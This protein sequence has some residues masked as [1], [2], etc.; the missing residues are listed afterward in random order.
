MIPASASPVIR[1]WD[2]VVR[3]FHWGVLTGCLANMFI[4]EEGDWA[5]NFV[6]YSVAAL[7]VIR[8]VWGIVGSSYARFSN[9][10]PRPR[11]A[12]KYASDMLKGKEDRI[13]GHNPLGALMI[14]TLMTLLAGVSV[15]GW[16]LTLDTWWGSHRLEE[17][18]EIFSNGI[19]VFAL[20]HV[21]GVIYASRHHH[22]NLVL[23]MVTGFKRRLKSVSQGPHSGGPFWCLA[24]LIPE[25]SSRAI[26]NETRDAVCSSRLVPVFLFGQDAP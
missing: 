19:L 22:E 4:L 13:I 6:G 25:C 24:S 20:I 21:A 14:L 26:E 3:I 5:H 11:T 1:V 10:V 8:L 17:V 12:L 9:F 15:T 7:L 23:A 18:H 16:M 2:P